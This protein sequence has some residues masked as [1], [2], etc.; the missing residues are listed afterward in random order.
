MLCDIQTIKKWEQ[1]DGS[2]LFFFS[3]DF[4]GVSIICPKNETGG[5]QEFVKYWSKNQLNLQIN[6]NS[7]SWQPA[8]KVC[9][10]LSRGV[11]MGW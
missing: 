10:L 9:K 6:H 3:L 11:D 4:V 7:V 5:F 1:K 2:Y 8:S